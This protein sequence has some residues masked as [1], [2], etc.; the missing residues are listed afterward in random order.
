MVSMFPVKSQGIILQAL[1]KLAKS[2]TAF[3]SSSGHFN[4]YN[5][6]KCSIAAWCKV[7]AKHLLLLDDGMP[8]TCLKG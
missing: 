6:G 1:E 7:L 2:A 3:Y 8:I 5:S 4:F